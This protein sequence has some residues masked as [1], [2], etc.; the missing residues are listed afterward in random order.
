MATYELV[1]LYFL[2]GSALPIFILC[3][4]P[5]TLGTARLASG[6]DSDSRFTAAMLLYFFFWPVVMF[7]WLLVFAKVI[8]P[9]DYN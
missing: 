3:L 1:L 6:L 8:D 7:V 4:D 2:I 9:K 5:D